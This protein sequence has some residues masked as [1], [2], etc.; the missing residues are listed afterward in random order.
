MYFLQAR[1]VNDAFHEAIRVMEQHGELRI[2]P[3]RLLSAGS[4]V[5][6]IV[7]PWP[8]VTCYSQPTERVLFNPQRDANPFFHFFE[9]L[10]ML[11]GH[12]DVA[13]VKRFV[14]RMAQ[15]SDDGLTFHG[16]YGFRW[17]HHFEM[18]GGGGRGA[19]PDQISEIVERLQRDPGDR[20]NVLAMWDPMS[21]LGANTKD[22]PCNTHAYFSRDRADNPLDMTVCCRSN[23]IVWGCYGSNAV[24]FSMLQEYVAGKIGCEV[25]RYYHL[26]NNW[27]AYPSTYDPVRTVSEEEYVDLY[28]AL[29][30]EPFP[31][32]SGE[33]NW[34]EGVHALLK[35][36]I[37]DPDKDYPKFITHVALPMLRAHNA[38][39]KKDY[40][41]A[42]DH[43]ASC[44][45]QDWQ[46]ACKDWIWRRF[47]RWKQAQDDGVNHD[48]Q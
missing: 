20:R 11:A 13:F 22:V 12:N 36:G 2:A 3:K 34:D 9:A 21:D 25:G 42:L 39:K 6:M 14:E 19:M 45:A 18:E 47:A 1:N 33:E 24:H 35:D 28:E 43:I 48:E 37:L 15:F 10:W 31:M 17:R 38:V 30:I 26:S 23:D 27:H 32:R 16:A 40:P 46:I 41:G 4:H 7:A 8:V 44:I 5:Q 29:N